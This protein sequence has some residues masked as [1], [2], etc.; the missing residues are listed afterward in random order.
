MNQEIEQILY[1]HGASAVG[2]AKIDG[3]YGNVDL[4]GPRSVDSVTEPINIPHFPIGISILLAF[5][6]NVI[7]NIGSSPTM[8]Y[9]NAYYSLNK[10]LDEIDGRSFGLQ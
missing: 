5:E 8:D 3:L 10:K 6:K 1:E 2:F 7:K 4:N 9:F